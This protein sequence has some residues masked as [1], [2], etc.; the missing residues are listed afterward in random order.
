M[1]IIRRGMVRRGGLDAIDHMAAA[2][3]RRA[4]LPKEARTRRRQAHDGPHAAQRRDDGRA[5]ATRGKRHATPHTWAHGPRRGQCCGG[6]VMCRHGSG[7][8]QRA[9]TDPRILLARS[10]RI[11]P[12]WPPSIGLAPPT[13]NITD[14]PPGMVR[15]LLSE[16]SAPAGRTSWP[17]TRNPR[18]GEEGQARG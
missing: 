12:S 17:P 18:V 9:K 5:R 13:T 4:T 16:A 14:Y 11:E 7:L 1:R 10:E 8:R 2:G 6:N 15:I 3:P